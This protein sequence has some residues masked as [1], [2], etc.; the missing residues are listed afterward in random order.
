MDVRRRAGDPARESATL[1]GKLVEAFATAGVA[2]W[3]VAPRVAPA[4]VAPARSALFR[5][6]GHFFFALR[7]AP[8]NT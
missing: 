8:L 6:I 1:T 5:K 7:V 4:G 3:R 2:A